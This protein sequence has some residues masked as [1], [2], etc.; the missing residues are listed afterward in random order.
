VRLII[1]RRQQDVKGMLGGHK[2]VNFTLSYRLELT[3]EEAELVER[4]KL[5]DYPVTW[6]T[7]QGQQ[8]PDD[9]IA[10]MIVG[11]SQTIADVTTLLKNESVVKSACDSLPPLFEV[12]R[13]FG[14][15]EII[16]Y[17]RPASST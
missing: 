3:P 6:K 4:Y 11:R 2:G 14:G 7:A 16:D 5:S 15:D 17:P 1:N 9:T 13:T 12:V 8:M 10:N